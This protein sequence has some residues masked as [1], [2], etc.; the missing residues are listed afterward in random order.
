MLPVGSENSFSNFLSI[1]L[2]Y[3]LL[4]LF[5][6]FLDIRRDVLEL[7]PI[8]PKAIF[9]ANS[10]QEDDIFKIWVAEKKEQD[11]PLIVGQHGGHFG[12]GK[13]NQTV[14]H[15]L[16]IAS[17]FGSWGW[18][19]FKHQNLVALPSM[20][21]SKIKDLEP[22]ENG[23]ILLVL[24]SLPRY[25]Y[26]H[27][28]V[29]VAGQFLSYLNDQI[30]FCN[31]LEKSTKQHLE[32]RLDPTSRERDWDIKSFFDLANYSKNIVTSKVSIWSQI[33]KSRLCICTSNSTVFLETLSRNFPTLIFWDPKYNEISFEAEPFIEE[34]VA[35]EILFFCP[36]AVAKKVNNISE[37]VNDWWF[38]EKV[39]KARK[40][41]CMKF[42]FTAND[43]ATDWSFFLHRGGKNSL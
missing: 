6:K 32:L 37:N 11:I 13:L 10:Y 14:D 15:Q 29:P 2:P 35:A 31:Q 16:L 40:N 34:L 1:I 27:Y 4:Y 36:S 23:N 21:L 22:T 20:Q 33:K 38:S 28:S 18:G 42:A 30:E 25:F 39:Q 24:T 41:F 17:A 3:L 43:W 9:T 8:S 19:Q 26:C 7:L 5:G 12:I